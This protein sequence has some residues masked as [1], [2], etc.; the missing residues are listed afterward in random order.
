MRLLL[1]L[2]L[3][4]LGFSQIDFTAMGFTSSTGSGELNV[5]V[6]QVAYSNDSVAS[7]DVNMGVQQTYIVGVKNIAEYEDIDVWVFPNP[8]STTVRVHIPKKIVKRSDDLKYSLF[9]VA[10]R[11]VRQ[12]EIISEETLIP[13]E[14]YAQGSYILNIV[15]GIRTL[16]TYKIVRS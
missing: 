1:L 12:D 15:D 16:G 3:P 10:G 4:S 8:T 11:L 2:F 13:M 6:G 7:G 5:T 14:F 9:D